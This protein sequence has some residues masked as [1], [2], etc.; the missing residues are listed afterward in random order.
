MPGVDW[1]KFLLAA[2]AILIIGNLSTTYFQQS[3]RAAS[4]QPNPATGPTAELRVL[5]STQSADGL[6]EADL[7]PQ[8]ASA[9]EKH[10]ASRISA[11]LDA[12]AK[13]GGTSLPPPQILTE[14]TV[15]QAQG[16]KLVIIRYEINATARAVE[17]VGI[18]GANADRVMCTREA[19]DEILLTVGPCAQKVKEVHGVG[20]GG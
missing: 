2:A 20:I 19:L 12:M 15:V 18:S 13:Q 9:L 17:I 3:D 16:K 11:K 4:P 7:T 14:S 6:T 1:K 8:L 5:S 10:G